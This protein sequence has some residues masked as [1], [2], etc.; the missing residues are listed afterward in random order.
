VSTTPPNDEQLTR[1]ALEESAEELYETAPCGYLSTTTNGHIIK[2][3]ATLIK[4]LGY[5]RD[6]LTRGKR[7]IDLLTPGGRIFYETHFHLMLR[8]YGE[9]S[10]IAFDMVC[11]NGSVIP[12]LVNAMQKRDA[13]GNP[14]VNRLTVFNAGERRSYEREL[15]MARRRADE[16]LAELQQSNAALLKA[17]E[18]LGQFAYAA[19]HDLQEPLRTITSYAQLFEKRYAGSLERPA[20]E[21]VSQIVDS[22]RRMQ[23]LVRDLLTY[24]QAQDSP[25]VLRPTDMN[26][27]LRMVL[28]NLQAAVEEAGTVITYDRLPVLNVDA[29]RLAQ[30]FQ[31]LIG[32]AIK[33]RKPN[34]APHVHVS[35]SEGEGE[36]TFTVR[37]NG[38]GFDSSYSDEIFGVFKRLHGRDIPG[39]GIGLAICKRVIESH[40][41]RIW[42]DS[43]PGVGSTF[44]FTIPLRSAVTSIG[45]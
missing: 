41:G 32:N 31:N 24:S 4:W 43:T 21:L 12:T 19:S 2:V 14:L 36:W 34:E 38:L 25:L 3:N 1:P 39:T 27:T 35:A 40:E 10:E 8:M 11:S 37:D 29:A 28:E 6:E 42:A 7:F 5:D 44:S 16:A 45:T 15:L 9:V 17:N 26:E 13:V 23:A 30:V 22:A 20:A 33:Y 18:H